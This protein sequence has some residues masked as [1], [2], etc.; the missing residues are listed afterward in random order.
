MIIELMFDVVVVFSPF[1]CG[2]FFLAAY[3]DDCALS[4]FSFF[5]GPI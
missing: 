5:C 4:F 1:S 3:S 2:F